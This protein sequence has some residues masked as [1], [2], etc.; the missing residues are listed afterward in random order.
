MPQGTRPIP[1]MDNPALFKP[2]DVMH[3]LYQTAS[4]HVKFYCNNNFIEQFV[5][6]ACFCFTS[7]LCSGGKNRIEGLGL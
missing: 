5:E 6:T 2:D 1:S 4:Q 7:L 3:E